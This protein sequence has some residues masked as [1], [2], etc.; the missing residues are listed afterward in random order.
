MINKFT[1]KKTVWVFALPGLLLFTVFVIFPLIPEILVSF[2]NHDGF[3]N[4]GWVG[5]S[6]FKA[7]INSSSFWLAN[8]NTFFIVFCSLLIAL[9]VSLLL[10]LLIDR[11]TE[12]IRDY[13]KFTAVFP[14]ILSVTVISQMWVAMLEPQ[15][16]LINSIFRWLGLNAWTRDW[17]TNSKTVVP[18]I[19]TAFLW[20]YIGLNMLLFYAGI[21]S[22]PKQYYEAAQ[23]DGAGFWK[24]SWNI[25][26]P[27]LKDIIKYV[28]VISTMGSMGMF[29]HTRIM[30]NGGPG[31]RSR[32]IIYQMYYN[33][34]ST[35]EFGVGC[36]VSLL[37]V[38]ECLIVTKI[39]NSSFSEERIEY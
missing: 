33:A 37:F 22:I 19:T 15:W 31:D 12:K 11:Q 34:F 4:K 14:A 6:N 17:L 39:I 30:T 18:C 1:S 32:T 29:A 8:K 7:V 27:L 10:A 23:L 26:I 9:P 5:L 2:Q 38:I 25:T 3:R 24:A 16:G 20:Q 28:V 13:F 35:S 36:A 21:K